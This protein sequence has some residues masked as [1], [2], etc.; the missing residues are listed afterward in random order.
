MKLSLG[1]S[2]FVSSV[3]VSAWGVNLYSGLDCQGTSFRHAG[4]GTATC[5]TNK[6]VPAGFNAQSINIGALQSSCQLFVFTDKNSQCAQSNN[7]QWTG[8]NKGVTG[9]QNHGQNKD[10][11]WQKYTVQ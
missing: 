10:G 11:N 7:C 1:I 8:F 2:V 6:G 3:Q 9:C 4:A 5:V